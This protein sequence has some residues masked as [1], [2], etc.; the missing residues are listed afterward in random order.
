MCSMKFNILNKVSYAEKNFSLSHT[1]IRIK[2][3]KYKNNITNKT[4][5]VINL[6]YFI[7][8]HKKIIIGHLSFFKL[9]D[10]SKKMCKL[11]FNIKF[12]NF[13]FTKKLFRGLKVNDT[14]KL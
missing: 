12:H 7:L 8:L 1:N 6:M 9:N 14:Y 4:A 5:K 3:Q 11:K 13:I 10:S 2:E